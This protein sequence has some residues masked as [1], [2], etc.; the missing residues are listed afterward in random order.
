MHVFII[1][2]RIQDDVTV[3]LSLVKDALVRRAVARTLMPG[4]GVNIHIFVPH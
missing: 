3:R 2:H 4:E 1:I